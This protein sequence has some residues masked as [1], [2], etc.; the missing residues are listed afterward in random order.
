LDFLGRAAAAASGSARRF[1]LLPPPGGGAAAALAGGERFL[2]DPPP[3]TA[4]RERSRSSLSADSSA[5]SPPLLSPSSRPSRL[6]PSRLRARALPQLPRCLSYASADVQET[7][8][9]RCYTSYDIFKGKSALNVKV[10]TPTFTQSSS[11][12]PLALKKAGA[13]LLECAPGAA[14]S[15][16]WSKKLA[17]ALSVT[18]MAEI[19]AFTAE[20]GSLEF[21]HDPNACALVLHSR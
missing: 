13:L 8:S 14:R 10:I 1:F 9:S 3:S 12:G 21:V 7:S 17:M 16:D 5:S 6:T 19:L 18:E 11:G 15:Y 4:A 20:A 2:A